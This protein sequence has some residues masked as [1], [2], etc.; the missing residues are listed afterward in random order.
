MKQ[1]KDYEKIVNALV[2][3]FVTKYYTYDDWSRADDYYLVWDS[4]EWPLC[5]NDDFR[6]IDEIYLALKHNFE[7]DTMIE[8]KEKEIETYPEKMDINFYHFC[9]YW[10][11]N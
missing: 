6:S 3:A 7:Y 11:T 9:K 1:V 2:E 5:V 8:Y 4:P 10:W